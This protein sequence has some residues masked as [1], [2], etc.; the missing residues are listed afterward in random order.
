MIHSDAIDLS[1]EE[2]RLT[3]RLWGFVQMQVDD[4]FFTLPIDREKQDLLITRLR[5]LLEMEKTS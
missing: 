3:L 1:T 4:G 5:T 2:G